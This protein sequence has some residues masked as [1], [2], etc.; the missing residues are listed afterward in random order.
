MQENEYLK[1]RLNDQLNWYDKKSTT[2]KRCYYWSKFI[3]LVCTASI[4]V[5]SVVFRQ[6][7]FTVVITATIAAIATVTEGILTLTK[8]H[9]KWIAYRSNAEALKH[10]KYSFLTSSG[11]YANLSEQEKFHALVDRTEN[12]ISNENTNWASLG[13]KKERSNKQ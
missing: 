2:Q 3:T 7:S 6:Q 10:E 12:I 9:E 11:A 8:W 4:P 5:I 13:K 1:R